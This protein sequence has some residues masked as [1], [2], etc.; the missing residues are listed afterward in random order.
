[1]RRVLAAACL[2][3]ALLTACGGNG[4]GSNVPSGDIVRFTTEDGVRLTGELRGQGETAVILSHMFPTDRLSWASLAQQLA[5]DGYRTLTYDFR[6][7]GDSDGE[8]VITDIWRDVLAAVAF[9]RERGANRIVLIGASMGGTASLVAAARERLDGVVTLSAAS[10][11]MGLLAP[12]EALQIIEEPKLF[13]AAEGDSQAAATAEQFYGDSPA[14]KRVEIVTGDE[15]GTD[16]LEGG[17]AEV[18]RTLIVD[19]LRRYG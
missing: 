4:G 5:A 18:V 19:F 12:P 1:M 15:H 14:P 8:K 13:I 9:M 17:Q 10:T 11:F 16:M 6:G 3:G 2:L 7:Y